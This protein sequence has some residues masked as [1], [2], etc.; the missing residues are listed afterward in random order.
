MSYFRVVRVKDGN[1]RINGTDAVTVTSATKLQA[2]P[3]LHFKILC[4]PTKTD[5]L[6]LVPKWKGHFR[7]CLNISVCR[8][9]LKCVLTQRGISLNWGLS[10]AELTLPLPTKNWASSTSLDDVTG[11]L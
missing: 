7:T 5:Y 8:K 3:V 6:L 1:S 2:E 10:F 9:V 11:D 4:P